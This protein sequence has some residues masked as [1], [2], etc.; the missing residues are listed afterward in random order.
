MTPRRV[1]VLC[2]AVGATQTISFVQPLQ[3]AVADGRIDLKVLPHE[4]TWTAPPAAQ[5]F[6]ADLKPDILVLSRYTM[7]GA[8]DLIA[9]AKARGAA[10]IFHLDDDLLA[11]PESLGRAKYEHYSEP[12]RVAALM[13]ALN[14]SDLIYASTPV[15]AARLAE[16]GIV[17]PITA[18]DIYCSIAPHD[19]MA[20]LPS[21]GPVIGYMATGGHGA[22]LD[23]VL[24]AIE[25]LLEMMPELRF[26]TFG[27]I[28]PAPGLARFGKRIA[29]FPGE[30]DYGAFLAR[31]NELGWWVAI[32]PLEDTPFNR[33]KADT[34]W[35]EYAFCGIPAVA[36]DLPVYHKAC[37]D[38][39]GVLAAAND[40]W[41]EALLRL[42]SDPRA[43]QDMLV[44]A[45]RRLDERYGREV[46]GRQVT[47]IFDQA[48]ALAF[49]QKHDR[50]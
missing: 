25:R 46:L 49:R 7:P 5:T 32:A 10:V 48:A 8:L 4:K 39:A 36:S 16:H 40:Q 37:A 23:L 33:C 42:V 43:R 17:A 35:I 28:P 6:I 27:T 38:G 41:F 21:T 14:A 15:L 20:P 3:Q 31:L 1:L 13:N 19:K 2:D 12:G 45:R 47:A 18:G 9:A 24:P 22:D 44:A 26:E 29:H 34:K 30:R 50:S 11:V